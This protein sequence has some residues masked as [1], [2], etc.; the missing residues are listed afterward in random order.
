MP[1]NEKQ[2]DIRILIS[3]TGR[4]NKMR[5]SPQQRSH[6]LDGKIRKVP[7]R[8]GSQAELLSRVARHR[9]RTVLSTGSAGAQMRGKGWKG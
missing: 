5:Q 7:L 1:V 6:N 4:K 2:I 8:G 3:N 9:V